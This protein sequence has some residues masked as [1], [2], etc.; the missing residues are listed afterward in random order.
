MWTL[1]L[2]CTVASHPKPT[3]TSQSVP[4]Y[5]QRELKP[6]Q[7]VQ[8]SCHCGKETVLRRDGSR[9]KSHVN[10]YNTKD[11]NIS[12]LYLLLWLLECFVV[13][14]QFQDRLK[15]IICGSLR[16]DLFCERWDIEQTSICPSECVTVDMEFWLNMFL[17]HV[18]VV[19][20]CLNCTYKLILS[21]VLDRSFASSV[22][23]CWQE[24]ALSPLVTVHL[25]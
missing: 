16:K 15:K 19:C 11:Q 2:N 7:Q 10:F 23:I 22:N 20:F 21:Y 6:E 14:P 4:V 25:Y 17:I 24:M 3:Y 13:L 8:K 5:G 12:C 18:L 9:L 1:K